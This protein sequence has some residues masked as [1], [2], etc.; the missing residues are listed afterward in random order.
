MRWVLL[1]AGLLGALAPSAAGHPTFPTSAVVA[2]RPD[3][4]M[5]IAVRHDALA[6][7]LNDTSANVSDPPMYALLN[8]P[9][10]SL[11]AAFDAARARFERL[12]VLEVDG[13]RV[14]VAVTSFPSTTAIRQWQKEF[15]DRRLPVK[16]DIEAGARL[17]P[18]A[19][20]FSVTFPEVLGETVVTIDRP[21]VEPLA[22]PLGAGERSPA[23]AVELRD[24]GG[25]SP[26]PA[27]T[28]QT[29]NHIGVAQVLWRYARL[30][31]TH[32]MPGGPDHMLFVLGLFLLVPRMKTVLWQITAFTI[33]HT[34][35]LTLAS[36]HLVNVGPRIV[37]PTI[38][39]TIAFIGVENLLTKRV[40]PWRIAVA[41]LFGLV[42]GLGVATAFNEAGFPTGQLVPSLGAF[43]LGVEGGHITVLAVAFAALGWCRD[44]P[45]YRSRVAVPLSILI[46]LIA[47]YWIIARLM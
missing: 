11:T 39:A 19:H 45:W 13:R 25:P 38:A 15:P 26:Q 44:K 40:H 9:D 20:R 47:L 5:D 30:G 10:E 28:T 8:G 23:F 42:H 34:V 36:L 24:A 29:P 46:S 41:F 12:F 21:G 3:G 6:F 1:L 37:E 43:T 32:I 14:P 27:P 22:L 33:A 4:T 18:G 31:F 35:T 2:V 17:S 16:M 7:A